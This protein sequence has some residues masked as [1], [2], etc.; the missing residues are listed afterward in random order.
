MRQR[1]PGESIASLGDDVRQMSQRAYSTLDTRAQE[2][3]ALNQLY[4]T[5]P[6][7]MKYRC[8]DKDCRS[9]S[10]AVEVV[11]R[12][13]AIMEVQQDQKKSNV[14]FLSQH[15][16]SNS[17]PESNT[18]DKTVERCLQDIAHRISRL[19]QSTQKYSHE[20]RSSNY[21]GRPQ[22][23]ARRCLICNEY[24]HV[25]RN[26]PTYDQMRQAFHQ[27]QMAYRQVPVPPFNPMVP[28][29]QFRAN[30]ANMQDACPQLPRPMYTNQHPG[31]ENLS[32]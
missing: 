30:P 19:E 8:M 13:E 27:T 9:V 17:R 29:P 5:I 28:P 20:D 7:E 16:E 3:L 31:N 32:A 15:P 21:Q 24:D 14:R 4:K 11:E 26:C 12:Y 25:M 18:R 23:Q 22:R 6:L 1:Q 2:A 10:D